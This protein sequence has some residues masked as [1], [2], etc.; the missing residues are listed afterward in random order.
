MS[1]FSV[2][3]PFTG[4]LIKINLGN[5]ISSLAP[6]P[7]TPHPHSSPEVYRTDRHR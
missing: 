2:G 6:L 1:L 5:K 7:L 3:A 4:L